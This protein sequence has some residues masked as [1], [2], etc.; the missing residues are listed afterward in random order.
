MMREAMAEGGVSETTARAL[1]ARAAT[2][3]ATA[4]AAELV[5][6]ASMEL[7][8]ALVPFAAAVAACVFAESA[9]PSP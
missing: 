5:P 3:A 4:Q 8:A 1:Q 9:P 2:V 6:V 7:E